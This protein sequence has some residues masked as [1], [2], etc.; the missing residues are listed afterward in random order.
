MALAAPVDVPDST[1][2]APS[3]VVMM[4]AETPGLSAAELIADAMPASVLLLESMV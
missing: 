2:R 3:V 1:K 4:L